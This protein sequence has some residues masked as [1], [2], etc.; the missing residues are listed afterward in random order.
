MGTNIRSVQDVISDLVSLGMIVLFLDFCKAF[1]SVNHLFMF[2]LLAHMGFPPEFISWIAL[3]YTNA[4]SVVKHNNWLM[5]PFNLQCGVCQGCPLSCHLFS[6]VRQV[7]IFLLRDSGYFE[8]WHFMNHPCSLYADDTAIFLSNLTQLK[9][10]LDHIALMGSFTRLTLNL[11]KT[12]AFDPSAA[13]KLQ[14]SGICVCNAPV[15]YLG[16]F[17]GLGDLSCLNFDQ[18]LKKARAVIGRWSK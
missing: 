4:I 13:H 16:A 10:V 1:D 9:P 17:L 15:K 3:L 5:E 8:W 7:L 6:L 12:I 18:P 14:V 11:E 2:T